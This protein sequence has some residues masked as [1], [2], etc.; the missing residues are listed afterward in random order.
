[1]T[2]D[3]TNQITC[4]S[5]HH[6]Q[7][8]V[9]VCLCVR[10]CILHCLVYLNPRQRVRHHGYEHVKHDSDHDDMVDPVQCVGH[11]LRQP[12]LV[13]LKISVQCVVV[14]EYFHWYLW[15]NNS[16]KPEYNVPHLPYYHMIF[17]HF[18][19]K[20]LEKTC[21]PPYCSILIFTKIILCTK[22]TT[23]CSPICKQ[24]LWPQFAIPQNMYQMKEE[25]C[26]NPLRIGAQELF[27]NCIRFSKNLTQP[28]QVCSGGSR[29]SRRGGLDLVGG[30]VDSRGG[31]VLKILYVE[32]KESGPLTVACA[33]SR[34]ANGLGCLT[35][36]AKPHSV[37]P[38]F[39]LREPIMNWSVWSVQTK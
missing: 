9:C 21:S 29:I 38:G 35:S 33:A 10:V 28:R 16:F 7:L 25:N 11:D 12:V 24:L 4:I 36:S 15:E 8:C 14:T 20:I 2:F 27:E 23:K 30:G 5:A 37:P 31:Y 6:E 13:L 39:G 26:G 19:S 34:S 18:Y 32:T 1:M 22:K 3:W 17:P